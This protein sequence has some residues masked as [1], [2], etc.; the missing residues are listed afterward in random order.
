[1]RY[2]LAEIIEEQ[3]ATFGSEVRRKHRWTVVRDVLVL[4]GL[5]ALV[6]VGLFIARVRTQDVG[7]LLAAVAVL[8][9]LI[10]NLAFALFDK[11]LQIRRD[12]LLSA[13]PDV[14]RL[15]DDLRSNVNYTVLVGVVLTAV[16]GCAA[17]VKVDTPPYWV[18][19]AIGGLLLHLLIMCLV[20]LRRFQQLHNAMKP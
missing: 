7:A 12:P 17:L 2:G 14:M 5:P 8:T 9:G 15:I 16:L 3:F 20:D 11:S 19:G 10:F 6:G 13:N 1:M 4:Y 18:A